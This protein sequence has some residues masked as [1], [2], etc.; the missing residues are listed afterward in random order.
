VSFTSSPIDAIK[1]LILPASTLAAYATA[2]M[3]RL[4]RTTVL[5]VLHEDYVRTARAK[6]L[7]A[8]MVARKHILPNAMV[9]VLTLMSLWFGRLLGGAVITESI[10][11]WPG[12]GK[13]ILSSILSKDY[14]VVQG[15]LLYFVLIFIVV[16][17]LTDLA[18][19]I[20]DP[21]IRQRMTPGGQG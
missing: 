9:P 10:F 14:A 15:A 21:R 5:E 1:H 13:L 2:S 20:L 4:V 16:N 8:S 17:F 6:G 3:S 11:A 18:Y 7:S 12:L 19:G